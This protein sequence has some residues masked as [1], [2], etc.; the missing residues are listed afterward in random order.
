MYKLIFFVPQHSC[1]AVKT[2]IFATGAGS[3]GNYSNC[4]WQVLGESQFTPSTSATPYIGQA[5][6]VERVAEYRVEV[7]C[8]E[9]NINAAVTALLQSHPYEKPAFE[10]HQ[11]QASYFEFYTQ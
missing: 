7:L 11:P 9:E 6:V 1:D 8:T 2:A 5:D 4:C 3:L 10:V